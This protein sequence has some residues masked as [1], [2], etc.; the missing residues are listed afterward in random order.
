[1]HHLALYWALADVSMSGS[2]LCIKQRQGNRRAHRRWQRTMLPVAV[3]ISYDM[4]LLPEPQAP[5]PA[6]PTPQQH[7]SPQPPAPSPRP[8]AHRA[9]AMR[10]RARAMANNTPHGVT[11]T[12]PT[13]RTGRPSA[14]VAAAGAS[15]GELGSAAANARLGSSLPGQRITPNPALSPPPPLLP[16]TQ[17]AVQAPNQ[18]PS[19]PQP[20]CRH[21]TRRQG[22]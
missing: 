20:P 7:P 14:A 4:R 21:P 6:A 18:L 22:P 13:R 16:P 19:S 11:H 12:T 8:A 3:A 10:T 1:M 5:Q 2:R 17:P 9:H 15:A